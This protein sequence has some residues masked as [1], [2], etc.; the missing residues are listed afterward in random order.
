MANPLERE[1]SAVFRDVLL[2][3]VSEEKA[4]TEYG[5]VLTED[6]RNVDTKTETPRATMK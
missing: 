1:P 3:Y 4:R 5:V 2:G 6:K